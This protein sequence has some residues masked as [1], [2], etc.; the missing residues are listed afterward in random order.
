MM[1]HV[2]LLCITG[3]ET[4]QALS[5]TQSF[6]SWKNSEE[7]ENNRSDMGAFGQDP[8]YHFPV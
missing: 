5:L 1:I 6:P 3:G 4:M 2:K 7:L 8:A